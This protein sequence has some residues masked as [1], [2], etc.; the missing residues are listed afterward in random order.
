MSLLSHQTN[1]YVYWPQRHNTQTNKYNKADTKNTQ[2]ANKER[3]KKTCTHQ[4]K[5]YTKHESLKCS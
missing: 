4:D 2:Y 1:E 5:H 3:D